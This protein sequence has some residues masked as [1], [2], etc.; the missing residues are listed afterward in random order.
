MGEKSLPAIHEKSNIYP[1][2]IKVL[3]TP[4]KKKVAQCKSKIN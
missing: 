1:K 4:P 3:K 2:H